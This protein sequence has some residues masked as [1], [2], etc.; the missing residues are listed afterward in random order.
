MGCSARPGRHGARRQRGPGP[1]SRHD[2]PVTIQPAAPLAVRRLRAR[3]VRQRNIP[4][5]RL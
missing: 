3:S 2:E 1:G 5:H 4:R